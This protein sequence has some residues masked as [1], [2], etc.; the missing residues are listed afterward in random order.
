MT[1]EQLHTAAVIEGAKLN[2]R[3]QREIKS[4]QERQGGLMESRK[5]VSR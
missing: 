3:I 4:K 1:Y 2:E 5:G